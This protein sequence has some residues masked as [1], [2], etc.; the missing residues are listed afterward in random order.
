MSY[1]KEEDLAL[2]LST[3]IDHTMD[4]LSMFEIEITLTSKGLKN[5]EEVIEASFKYF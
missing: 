3:E 1:L 2:D 5:Y 4:C